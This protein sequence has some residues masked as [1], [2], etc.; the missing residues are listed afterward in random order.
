MADTRPQRPQVMNLI[1]TWTGQSQRTQKSQ[2]EGAN[3]GG[4]SPTASK[5]P[6]PSDLTKVPTNNSSNVDPYAGQ[7]N[8]LSEHQEAQLSKFKALIEE[9]GFYRP[10]TETQ[11]A[12][13]DDQTLL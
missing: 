8:H 7:L 1:R 5:R 12:S 2:T 13:H 6:V 11:K 10:Q 3:Q 9:K 4:L